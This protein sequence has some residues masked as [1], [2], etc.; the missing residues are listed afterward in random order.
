MSH[1]ERTYGTDWD[2]VDAD[3]AVERAYA[4]GVA[5]RLGE[6][7]RAEL[8]RLYDAVEDAYEQSLVELAYGQGRTEAVE[9][10]TESDPDSESELWSELVT[11]DVPVD[12][13]TATG[14]PDGLPPALALGEVL[15]L[16]APDSTDALDLPEFL[17]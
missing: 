9:V 1:Y 5:E 10:A 6:S 12:E 8:E 16:Q 14:Q 7:N 13:E 15:D 11:G 17:D 4:I 2:E 3:E